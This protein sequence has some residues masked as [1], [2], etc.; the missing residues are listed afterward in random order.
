MN[1]GLITDLYEVEN[2]T[3]H[4]VLYSLFKYLSKEQQLDFANHTKNI[5]GLNVED[6]F[7]T[8]VIRPE[9]VLEEADQ[10]FSNFVQKDF[11][12]YFLKENKK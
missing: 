7:W 1:V 11:I 12:N 9:E 8:E 3:P 5:Y 6:A 4:Q 2:Y 10:F